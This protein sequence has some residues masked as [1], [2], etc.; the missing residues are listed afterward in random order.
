MPKLAKD[1][2][3]SA[4]VLSLQV[5]LCGEK[6]ISQSKYFLSGREATPLARG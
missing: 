4:E 2:A 5:E 1:G 3:I 6:Q